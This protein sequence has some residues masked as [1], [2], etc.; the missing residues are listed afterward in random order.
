M[1]VEGLVVATNAL[2]I[3]KEDS[4]VVHHSMHEL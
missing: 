1:G 4:T 2:L 3:L